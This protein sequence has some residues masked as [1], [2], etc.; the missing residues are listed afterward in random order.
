MAKR[1][2]RSKTPGKG[3]EALIGAAPIGAVILGSPELSTFGNNPLDPIGAGT[4]PAPPIQFAGVDDVKVW[5]NGQSPEAAVVFVARAAL[6]TIPKLKFGQRGPT[7][8][9]RANMLGVLRC[10]AAAW[11]IAAYPGHRAALC[12]AAGDSANRGFTD[13]DPARAA[14]YAATFAARLSD[15]SNPTGSD[16]ANPQAE[17][18]VAAASRDNI[19]IEELLRAFAGDAWVLGE[20]ISN[21]PFSQ[22]WPNRVPDWAQD[23]WEALKSALLAANEGWEV[24]TN[25]YEARIHGRATNQDIEVA[26]ATIEDE[27]WQQGPRVVN[28]HIRKLIED[29]T[30]RLR[31]DGLLVGG[32]TRSREPDADVPGMRPLTTAQEQPTHPQ[33]QN[34]SGVRDQPPAAGTASGTSTASGVSSSIKAAVGSAA[35]SATVMGE[36]AARSS[37]EASVET[38]SSIGTGRVELA[39]RVEIIANTIASL[40]INSLSEEVQQLRDISQEIRALSDP[41]LKDVATR[42]LLV[43]T[44]LFD[45]LGTQQGAQVIIAGA[46]AGILGAAGWPA[47]AAYG[48]TLAAWKGKDAFMAALGNLPKSSA[49]GDGDT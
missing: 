21:L 39:E 32:E 22:L 34:W 25:W 37:I 28:A 48:L 24:W 16:L 38:R 12:A 18:V 19:N 2:G 29:R 45:A 27:I 15:A 8:A 6:R 30:D 36:G 46:V 17:H 3:R 14:A 13:S 26:R 23:E 49:S 20:R 31:A 9:Q 5:L 33:P 40:R 35:G 43:L 7:E 10:A 4:G 1:G 47:V 11:A 41:S 42:A 44:Q